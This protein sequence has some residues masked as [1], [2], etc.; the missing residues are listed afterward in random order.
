LS[1]SGSCCALS[2]LVFGANPVLVTGFV[3]VWGAAVIAD[4]GVFS[5]ALSEVV[6]QRYVGTALTTQTSVGFLLTIVSIHVVPEIADLTSW[7]FAF[8]VL[9]IGPLLGVLAMRRF[10]QGSREALTL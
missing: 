6:D 10:D 5:T 2:P 7:R 1:V 8:L 9:A 4:S 3:L